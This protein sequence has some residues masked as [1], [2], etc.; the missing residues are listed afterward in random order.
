MS[1]FRQN[2]ATKEWVIIAPGRDN[3][4]HDYKTVEGDRP[5]PPEHRDDCP[6][7]TGNEEKTANELL[8]LE[9]DGAWL[10][11]VVENKFSA[12]S[13][14][15]SV[16]REQHGLFLK[17][18]SY[19]HAEVIIESPRH[20]DTLVS[21]DIGQV[22]DLLR[23]YRQRMAEISM[24]PNIAIVMLFRNW[25][26]HAGTSLEHP[27]SQIIASPIIP[28][29]IRDPFQK[30]ALHYDSYG[31]CV[32]CDMLREEIRQ[33]ERLVF[34]N[35]HYVVFCPFA[36]RTPYE[37]RIYP[38]VHNASYFWSPKEESS[39][40]AE[41]LQLTLQG[42][43]KLLGHQSYNLLVRTSPVGDEDVR[44]LH[45]YMVIV[46]RLSTPAGFEMGSGIYINPAA[47]EQCA[48]ELRNTL[49]EH[50]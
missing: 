39:D 10:M 50:G 7:C 2:L 6:F 41:A 42:M 9:R 23:L 3:R 31:S 29:H 40:L 18:G 16:E 27:H 45:W 12:L 47:P 44:Y 49:I 33:Q 21:M 32:Y 35:E 37:L 24:L 1:E 14:D 28:P 22:H 17:S 26:P 34:E 15:A 48:R 5:A 4:P 30:A 36:S 11:R 25:G 38:K 43:R 19:G 46:P 13:P 20:N 8:R